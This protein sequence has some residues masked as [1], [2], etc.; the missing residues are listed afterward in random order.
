MQI[1]R[2][3]KLHRTTVIYGARG[4]RIKNSWCS[5][6]LSEHMGETSVWTIGTFYTTLRN[7]S[8]RANFT[9]IR[10]SQ[11]DGNCNPDTGTDVIDKIQSESR[12][13]ILIS[14]SR[15]WNINQAAGFRVENRS[16]WQDNWVSLFSWFCQSSFSL[17]LTDIKIIIYIKFHKISCACKLT[18]LSQIRLDQLS[19]FESAHAP[20]EGS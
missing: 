11:S 9:Y 12:H 19:I 8:S 13:V 16:V 14:I 17:T 7:E 10:D 18:R 15:L 20:F 2:R 3:Q 1:F 5:L 4:S 6:K